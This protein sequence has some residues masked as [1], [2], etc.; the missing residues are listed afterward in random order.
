[1]AGDFFADPATQMSSPLILDRLH[2]RGETIKRVNYGLS[3]LAIASSD[4]LIAAVAIL[5]SIEVISLKCFMQRGV[6]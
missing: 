2:N 3:N 1:M 6:V 4:A 5:I